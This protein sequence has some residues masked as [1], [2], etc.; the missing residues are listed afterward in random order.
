[1]K[2]WKPGWT[3]KKYNIA[4]EYTNLYP[5]LSFLTLTFTSVNGSESSP[6]YI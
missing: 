1:M 5:E 3:E 6:R 4:S 2:I